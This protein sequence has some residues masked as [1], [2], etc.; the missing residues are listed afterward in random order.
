MKSLLST[1]LLVL[2]AFTSKSQPLDQTKI[3]ALDTELKRH[4]EGVSPGLAIGIVKD[5]EVVYESYRGYANLEHEVPIDETTRF[6]IASNAKQFNAL[7]ILKLVEEGSIR[8]EDDFRKFLPDYLPEIKAPIQISHLLSHTSGIRDVYDLWALQGKTWW[9]EFV[10]NKEALELLRKQKELNFEPGSAYLY[11]NSNYILLTEIIQKVS[12]TDFAAFSLQLFESMGM[13]NTAFLTNY[14]EVVPNRA[15]PYG[16]WNGWK[17]YPSITEIHGDGGLF[18]T[19][20]DQLI[21]ERIIQNN[22]GNIVSQ[23][24]VNESQKR[25]NTPNSEAYGYGLMF[26]TYKNVNYCYH[27]GNTGAYNAT[28]LR[29]PEQKTAIIVL[30]NSGS[31]PTNYVAKQVAT[32][33]LGLNMAETTF[34][35]GP[36]TVTKNFTNN[37]AIGYYSSDDGNIIRITQKNDT[38]YRNIYQR[39]P[40]RL[41]QENGS[42]YHY[43]SNNNLKMAFDTSTNVKGF[44]IYL[45]SQAPISYKKLPPFEAS[46]SYLTSMEG[47]FYNQETDTQIKIEHLK[48]TSYQITKN[49]RTREAELTYKDLLQMNDYRIQVERNAA[50]KVNGLRID[51]GRIK[52]VK[53]EKM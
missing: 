43:E 44:T 35:A 28:F 37:D 33:V 38:L 9:Q 3:L 22:R 34:P 26:G 42:V 8:L 16:N 4:S 52:N 10:G 36:S 50:N 18:T 29:F 51:H 23:H 41:F 31:V 40:V 39:D 20:K 14:M 24:I 7:C 11:S 45:A 21:W 5:G 30:S 6:N 32:I 15:R 1:I 13:T 25:I 19:L 47:Q 12:D 48:G 27:D 2:L 46:P 53:F 49:D 17:E